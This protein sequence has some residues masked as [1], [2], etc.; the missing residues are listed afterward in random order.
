M[1]G[2]SVRTGKVLAV[3]PASLALP[4]RVTLVL[5]PLG[6]CGSSAFGGCAL[7][8]AQGRALKCR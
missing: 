2:L 3:D 4:L 6:E 7:R 5:D 1:V 8:D